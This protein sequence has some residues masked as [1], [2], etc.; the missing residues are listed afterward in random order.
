MEIT[1][2]SSVQLCL[3]N[4]HVTE[5]NRFLTM[6]LNNKS[7]LSCKNIKENKSSLYLNYNYTNCHLG[8]YLIEFLNL[9]LSNFNDFFKF[10]CAFLF[11]Y[12]D[13]IPKMDREKILSDLNMDYKYH[14]QKNTKPFTNIDLLE[15]YSKKIFKNLEKQNSLI[16][17]QKMFKDA[18]DY[19][20]NPTDK[21][22]LPLSMF[23]RFY[24]LQNTNNELSELRNNYS[25]DYQLR[26]DIKDENYM[27]KALS[28]ISKNTPNPLLDESYLVNYLLEYDNNNDKI[29]GGTETFTTSN[30]YTYFYII[31][32]HI[33]LNKYEY[34]NK[35][36]IC[37]NYFLTDKTS[38]IY[39]NNIYIDN[40]TCKEYGI[41]TSQKRKENEEPVYGK[42]RQIYA[43]KAMAVRRNP[44]IEYYKA[45]YEKWKKEAK[46]FINDIKADKKTYDEFDEWLDNNI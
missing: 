42:Y 30:I 37:G 35:C 18:I 27:K 45:N 41:K 29:Y 28:N 8:Y 6:N 13:D 2:Y 44:D 46:K 31:L 10:F 43:K 5:K 12:I 22:L 15:K 1:P 32:Y 11:N 33:V 39:C 14:K 36:K 34:I 9:N 24:I 26:F 4:S 23:Q 19:I 20:F 17:M 38:A 25:F 40:M 21:K 7:I 16:R 3:F